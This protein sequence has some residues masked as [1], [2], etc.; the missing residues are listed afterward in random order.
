MYIDNAYEIKG[1]I[2][3][4]GSKITSMQELKIKLYE[5]KDGDNAEITFLRNGNEQKASLTL[6][7]KPANL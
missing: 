7:T 5:Y 2:A 4:D 3:I 6:K 1:I